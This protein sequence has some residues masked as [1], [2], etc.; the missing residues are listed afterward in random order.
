MIPGA[1][2]TDEVEAVRDVWPE[3][4]EQRDWCY[5]LANASRGCPGRC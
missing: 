2:M 4:Q 5:K 3:T 1:M